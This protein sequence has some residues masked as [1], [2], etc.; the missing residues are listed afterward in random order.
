MPASSPG[1]FGIE[2][3]CSDGTVFQCYCP[4]KEY[5]R[6]ELY[7]AIRNKI[8]ADLPKLKKNEA[9]LT[10]RLGEIKVKRWILVTPLVDNNDLHA[11]A[12]KKE[13]EA[14]AWGIPLLHA[15]FDIKLQ[16]AGFYA[17]EFEQSRRTDGIAL[18][19][20]PVL[21]KATV[22]PDLPL[23]YLKLIERKNRVLLKSRVNSPTFNSELAEINQ[24][25]E[26]EFLQC[27]DN[28]SEI[29][30]SSPQAYQKLYYV[31]GQYGSE[32]KKKQLRWTG[33]PNELV[34]KIRE[35][36]S[37]RIEAELAGAISHN[38][39]QRTVDLLISRWLAVCQ[40][41]VRE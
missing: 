22:L 8:T 39:V 7:E 41:D 6:S 23:E 34:E 1:D 12:R 19:I 5:T 21:P 9:E 29:E 20:G 18:Q 11:H 35:E 3:W 14:K 38:S 16:D 28:L 13:L 33:E 31:I 24:L 4:E 2:G 26:A 10:K 40:L 17:N 27:D 32:M 36:L 15:D 37:Q 25:T 30:R